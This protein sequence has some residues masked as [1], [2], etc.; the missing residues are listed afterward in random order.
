M[1]AHTESALWLF[2]ILPHFVA[3]VNS[4]NTAIL[5]EKL[6]RTR[7][8]RGLS[9]ENLAQKTRLTRS[10]LSQIENNKTSPSINSLV[11]IAHALGINI[12]DFFREEENVENLILHPEDRVSFSIERNRLTVD[13]LVPRNKGRKFDPMFMRFGVGGDS[14]MIQGTEEPFFMVIL[15]GELELSVDGEIYILTAG[16]SIYLDGSQQTRGKNIGTTDV[17]AFAVAVTPI[18]L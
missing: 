17:T 3:V 9:L 15:Q 1:P 2:I 11:S 7:T 12:G 4:K 18:V 14:G 6:K 16:D 5:G 10:F 8:E 13:L